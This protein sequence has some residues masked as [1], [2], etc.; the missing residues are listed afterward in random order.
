MTRMLPLL[1]EH[2]HEF[3]SRPYLSIEPSNAPAGEKNEKIGN[4]NNT[5]SGKVCW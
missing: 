2:P 3:R 1:S 5:V 4:V